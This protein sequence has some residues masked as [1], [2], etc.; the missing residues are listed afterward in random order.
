MGP[1][2]IYYQYLRHSKQ[3][4]R[5][6]LYLLLMKKLTFK[7]E[8][9]RFQEELYRFAYKL[10]TDYDQANDL[11]QETTLKA[12]DN[13]DKYQPHTNMKSWLYTIMRNI[14]INNYHRATRSNAHD[15]EQEKEQ[16][17]SFE[18]ELYLNSIEKSYD[19]KEMWRIVNSLPHDMK[20]PF[21]LH[22]S[23]FMY[24]EISTMLGVPI[25]TV[26]S[27]IYATRIKLQNEL[28]DFRP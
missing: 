24:R 27:R 2:A 5:E 23:G 19:L 16:Q 8:L 17:A 12:L 22:V 25:G 20:M 11:L 18:S 28:K 21:S 26:K 13:E 14:F 3:T 4:T 15:E 7:S 10:T 1:F 9:I 6:N